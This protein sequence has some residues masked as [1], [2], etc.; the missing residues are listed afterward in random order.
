MRGA[1]GRVGAPRVQY[2]GGRGADEETVNHSYLDASPGCSVRAG[3]T[4]SGS[5]VLR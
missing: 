2:P 1:W 4:S 3:R 5:L